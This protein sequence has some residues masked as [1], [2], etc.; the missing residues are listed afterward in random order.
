MSV[1]AMSDT[2]VNHILGS[3]RKKVNEEFANNPNIRSGKISDLPEISVFGSQIRLGAD[4]DQEGIMTQRSLDLLAQEFREGSAKGKA[5][6]IFGKK[7]KAVDY[8]KGPNSKGYPLVVAYLESGKD[9][10]TLARAAAMLLGNPNTFDQFIAWYKI[11]YLGE[12]KKA[13]IQFS[14]K[15]I[16]TRY[17]SG[18]VIDSAV[19]GKND[20][21]ALIAK[22]VAHR[23]FNA[24]FAQ[25]IATKNPLLSE[26]I[27]ANTDAGHFLGIFNL[28]FATILDLEVD[29]VQGGNVYDL[30]VKSKLGNANLGKGMD[31]YIES[32]SQSLTLMAQADAISSNLLSNISL[33]STTSK[34]VHTKSKNG[35]YVASTEI[36]ISRAN[37]AAG[38]KLSAA[39][40]QLK[41][42]A[43]TAKDASV[44]GGIEGDYNNQSFRKELIKLFESI[45]TLGSYIDSLADK[46]NAAGSTRTPEEKVL[47]LALKAQAGTIANVLKDTSGSDSFNTAISKSLKAAFKGQAKLAEQYTVSKDSLPLGNP[48]NKKLKVPNVKK[49]TS[50]TTSTLQTP[51]KVKIPKVNMSVDQTTNLIGL[52]TLINAQL[53]ERVK[54]NM[55][56]GN[57][58]DILNLRTGR[59]AESVKVERLSES[60][61]GMITAFYTY[62]RNPYATFSEGGKQQLPRSRDPKLLI[63]KSIRQIAEAKVQN[64]LRAVLV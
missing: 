51:V 14:D 26:F 17:E 57:R 12:L 4:K 18:L 22:G 39:A 44:K 28:K 13:N 7:T 23:E 46:I 21:K 43:Q 2:V 59:F 60:R 49:S 34:R 36:Q 54:Q 64:R 37:Q 3:L 41:K 25:F 47:A 63:S 55:G 48:S 29:Q 27:D 42:L 15:T 9:I 38:R 16:G 35:A 20:L 6:D 30:T 33:A 19:S 24:R 62:M 32:M 1:G 8:A 40:R 58:K 45:S 52:Q 10:R 5:E 53:I 50:S 11:K 56:S 61:A 31:T